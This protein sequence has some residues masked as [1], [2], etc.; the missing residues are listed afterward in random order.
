MRSLV[1]GGA[2][3]LG[4]HLCDRLLEDGGEVVVVDNL[5]TGRSSNLAHLSGSGSFRLIEHDICEPLE[6]PERFDLV[7]NLASPASPRD[8]LAAPVETLMA[9]AAGTRNMLDLALRDGAVFV[10]AST[11]EAYGDPQVHPQPE[12]YWGNVNP[13]GPRA[14]YDESKRFAEALTMAYHRKHGVRTR[15]TRLF[16][17][18]GPRMKRSDGRVL[19]A[20]LDQLLRGE[21]LTV[22][23]EGTQTRCFCY[24][25]DAVDGIIRLAHS[26]ET[27]PVNIGSPEELT[28]MELACLVQKV[29]G[30]NCGIRYEPLPQDDPK[31][32]WPDIRKASRVLGWRPQ[33]S[34]E[35]GIQR[36]LNAF[37]LDPE[38][39]Q[40][41]S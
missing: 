32:R 22:F 29:A 28:V 37:R 16:N 31:R 15:L 5:S 33:V 27:S 26:R 9:G 40:I 4:S 13:V 35:E 21:P 8:Y 36:T 19:P 18:Y 17:V 10:H 7:F 11:S 24:V 25:S 1:S 20:F 38:D 23:G 6:C 39:V 41:S 14:V 34:L 12:S 3:F 2:G 30:R